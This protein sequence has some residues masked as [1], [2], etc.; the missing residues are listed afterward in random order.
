MT[1]NGTVVETKPLA[2]EIKVRFS[3][4][5]KDTVKLFKCSDVKVISRPQK[6]Q[7][8]DEDEETEE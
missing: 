8:K 7:N 2:E 1:G 5:D 4:N 3:D 6:R